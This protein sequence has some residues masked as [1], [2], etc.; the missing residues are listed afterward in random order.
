M[1]VGVYV[2][3]VCDVC[4]FAITATPFIIE[5]SNFGL[6]ILMWISKNGFLKFLKEPFLYISLR[7]LWAFPTLNHRE[8]FYT[9]YLCSVEC[10]YLFMYI[11]VYLCTICYCDS[12]HI[13]Q[14]KASKLWHNTPHG[15]ILKWFSH[16]FGNFFCR[17]ISLF[18]YFF[19]IS[20]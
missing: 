4:V 7:F 6:T 1:Y 14:H 2:C 19:K 16:F 15:T 17:V 5:L 8:F 3:D 10:L 20:L 11:C 18:L 9:Y 12:S 13:I